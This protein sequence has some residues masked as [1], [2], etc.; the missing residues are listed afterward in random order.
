MLDDK[1]TKQVVT[2]II[3]IFGEEVLEDKSRF[4]A[5]FSDF[6]PELKKEAA[7]FTVALQQGIGSVLVSVKD[8]ERD[9]AI[10][11]T[12]KKLSFILSDEAIT[13]V[14]TSIIYALGWNN[15]SFESGVRSRVEDSWE[16]Y[17]HGYN[18]E[19]GINGCKQNYVEAVKWYKISGEHGN[20][21]AQNRLG[22]C[23]KNGK[24][25]NV[26]IKEAVKWYTRAA[27]RGDYTAQY[28]LGLCYFY[29]NGIEQ[30][31]SIAVNLFFKSAEQGHE[32]AQ[33]MMG[34]IYEYGIGIPIDYVKA[35]KWYMRSAEQGN[36]WSQNRLGDCYRYGNGVKCDIHEA[37]KF[38]RMSADQGDETAISNLNQCLQQL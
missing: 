36:A 35:V 19:F 6:A 16:Q 11:K 34:Y 28:N 25:V 14:L 26:D 24:G 30:D 8:K 29:G 5:A 2:K 27:D 9:T 4:I 3:E 10:S 18:F 12:K 22:D 20:V 38:Y 32:W 17:Q 15:D 31:Y 33:Y 1:K 23:Y 21:W 13:L 7:I 37:I